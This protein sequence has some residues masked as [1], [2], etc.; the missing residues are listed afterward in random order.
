MVV[1]IRAPH[2]HQLHSQHGGGGWF[3]YSRALGV[4]H[5]NRGTHT[6]FVASPASWRLLA[7]GV[8]GWPKIIMQVG[9]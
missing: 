6:P 1:Y 2:T 9:R 4:A 8:L 7:R 3:S 5:A